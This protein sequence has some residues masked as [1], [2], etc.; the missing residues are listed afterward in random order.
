MSLCS[1]L[2]RE[3]TS[4][5][6]LSPATPGS[7]DKVGTLAEQLFL[8]VKKIPKLRVAFNVLCS[9]CYKTPSGVAPYS[10]RA[11]NRLGAYFDRF[12]QYSIL[13][14]GQESPDHRFL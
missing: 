3:G 4:S 11:L 7:G 12:G 13:G 2:S 1:G 8:N 9:R 5:S 10:K 6:R 14:D